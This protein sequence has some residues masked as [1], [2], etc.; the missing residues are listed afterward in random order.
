MSIKKDLDEELERRKSLKEEEKTLPKKELE[1][2]LKE[3]D[4]I[5]ILEEIVDWGRDK[6]FDFKTSFKI[7]ED[8]GAVLR[9]YVEMRD[10]VFLYHPY[11]QLWCYV[12]EDGRFNKDYKFITKLVSDWYLIKENNPHIYLENITEAEMLKKFKDIFMNLIEN[13]LIQTND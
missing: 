6:G 13:S 12:R 5:S 4:I 1:K 2:Y 8:Y 9:F 3:S 10:G 7:D 11:L